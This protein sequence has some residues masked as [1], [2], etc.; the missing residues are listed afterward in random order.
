[1]RL[2]DDAMLPVVTVALQTL[3]KVKLQ[4]QL[5]VQTLLASTKLSAVGFPDLSLRGF[6]A[7]SA[8]Y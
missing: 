5:C 4:I 7:T 6:A 8:C 1:V 2:R 3:W